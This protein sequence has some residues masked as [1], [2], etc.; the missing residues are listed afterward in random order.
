MTIAEVQI[1][2]RMWLERSSNGAQGVPYCN[3]STRGRNAVAK[4][5]LFEALHGYNTAKVILNYWSDDG[6]GNTGRLQVVGYDGF[7][8]ELPRFR[9]P[10]IHAC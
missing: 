9:D 3:I 8:R 2:R 6:T 7:P 5:E 10:L 1:C 4:F